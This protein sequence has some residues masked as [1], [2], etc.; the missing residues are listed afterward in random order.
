MLSDVISRLDKLDQNSVPASSSNFDSQ[1]TSLIV[2]TNAYTS[3]VQNALGELSGC[4]EIVISIFPD[5]DLFKNHCRLVQAVLTTLNIN[6]P[7]LDSS[8][9]RCLKREA[10]SNVLSS[11][12]TDTPALLRLPSSMSDRRTSLANKCA[13]VDTVSRIVNAKK[14]NSQLKWSSVTALVANSDLKLILSSDFNIYVNELLT[15][16]TFKLLG[17]ATN[18]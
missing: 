2:T 9:V 3:L 12:S 4:T 14:K 18:C 7:G 1:M 5:N 11:T 15:S 6:V 13:D 16:R 10:V 8:N 17:E